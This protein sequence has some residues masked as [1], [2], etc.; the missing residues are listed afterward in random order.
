MLGHFGVRMLSLFGRLNFWTFVLDQI[1][2]G[3]KKM[4]KNV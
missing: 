2:N 4:H 1:A 3:V